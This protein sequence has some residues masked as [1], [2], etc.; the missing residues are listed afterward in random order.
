M[1]VIVINICRPLRLTPAQKCVLMA[2]ADRADD[3]GLSWPS[4]P[5]ICAWTCFGRTAV[6]D[7]LKRLE[8]EGLVQISKTPGRSNLCA[9]DLEL[10]RRLCP[11]DQRSRNG[12]IRPDGGQ[13]TARDLGSN[14]EPPFS[15]QYASRTS[16][17]GEPVRQADYYP[18]VIRTTTSPPPGLTRP[19]GGPNTSLDINKTL[20]RHGARAQKSIGSLPEG[21]AELWDAYPLKTGKLQA[22]KA[23]RAL[24]PSADVLALILVGLG[25]WKRHE[26]WRKDGGKYRHHA[27][28]WITQRLWEDE[29]VCGKVHVSPDATVWWRVAG[30]DHIAEAQNA[31]CH[32]GNY[33][34]FRDGKRIPAEEVA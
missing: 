10:V 9:I 32:I 25:K 20:D 27:S 11:A 23:F 2:L 28:T 29:E 31:R 13:E 34:E 4:I 3:Y 24:S 6:I 17:G 22:I 15:N 14:Q 7:A 5:W 19:P 16:P 18:S 26:R 8:S 12:L 1:S 33:R 30:F 21:F